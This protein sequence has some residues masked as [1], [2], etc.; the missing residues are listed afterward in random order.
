MGKRMKSAL[1]LFAVLALAPMAEAQPTYS[2]E[3]SRLF[4]AKCQGCHREGDI[5]PFAL[6]SYS[7]SQ[8]WGED[9][10]RVLRD[11]IMPPWKPVD[12][13]GK[14]KND[15]GLTDE[16]RQTILDWYKAGAPEGDAADLPEPVAQSGEWQL[17]EPEIGRAHV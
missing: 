16:E 10:Q 3:I 5:A 14:F 15:F 9:I 2:K 11:R 8:S 6:D 17:G 12:A 13:H 4:Q 1:F 7:A